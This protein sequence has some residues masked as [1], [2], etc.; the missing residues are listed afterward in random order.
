MKDKILEKQIHELNMGNG[1]YIMVSE[2]K[3][4]NGKESNLKI[5]QT[6]N[7]LKIDYNTTF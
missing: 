4:K 1:K 7:E 6:H 3:Y 5:E 2:I